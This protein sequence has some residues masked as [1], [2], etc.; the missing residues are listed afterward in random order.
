MTFDINF[1]LGFLGFLA[2]I[3]FG[4]LSIYLVKSKKY[5]GGLTFISEETIGLF[6]SIIK[7]FP[8][9]A[10]TY[11]DKNINQQIVLLKGFIVNTGSIDI[12]DD[13]VEEN[14]KLKLPTNFKWLNVKIV[15][16]TKGSKASTTI[17][18]ENELIFHLGLFRKNE[19][20]RFEALADVPQST[21]NKASAT[22]I[23]TEELKFEHRIADTDKVEIRPMDLELPNL[24]NKLYKKILMPAVLMIYLIGLTFLINQKGI[25]SE[26]QYILKEGNVII[27]TKALPHFEN[28]TVE[29][30]RVDGADYKTIPLKEFNEKLQRTEIKEWSS[31][32]WIS[33]FIGL[34]FYAM[35]II[36]FG[37]M[38]VFTVST[39]LL[40]PYKE[41]RKIKKIRETL[42]LNN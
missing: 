26:F 11:N 16:S 23:L 1:W 17:A 5:P 19:F 41:Y 40:F 4:I 39:N 10:I 24:K 35:I 42:N 27:T 33:K 36:L 30:K 9:I 14:L 38:F 6:D 29:L 7:N 31:N 37:I 34:D 28:K 22:I 21:E 8:Q 25:L 32:N 18:A 20:L 13:L 2:T 12:K 3:I 15:D